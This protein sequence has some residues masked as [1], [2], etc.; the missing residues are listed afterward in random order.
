M[1]AATGG[2]RESSIAKREGSEALATPLAREQPAALPRTCRLRPPRRAGR[3]AGR[4]VAVFRGAVFWEKVNN[5]WVGRRR[6]VAPYRP[7]GRH[8]G[9]TTAS[10]T[11]A[12][13]LYG[14]RVNTRGAP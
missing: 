8:I 4:A 1:Y 10:R 7:R 2:K 11:P 5:A 9:M 14:A 3:P 13:T 6:R 12:V